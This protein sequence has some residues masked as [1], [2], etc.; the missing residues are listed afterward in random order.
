MHRAFHYGTG[1]AGKLMGLV[2]AT[3][4]LG[5]AGVPRAKIMEIVTRVADKKDV[6]ITGWLEA[7][8]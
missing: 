4:E 8:M 3:M 2:T 5:L 7:I 6:D 1:V